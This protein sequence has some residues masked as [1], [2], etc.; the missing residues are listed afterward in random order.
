M[1]EKKLNWKPDLSYPAGKGATEQRF[2]ASANGD[3]LEIDTHPWGD[4]DLKIDGLNA[5]HVEGLASDGDA[6]RAAEN[7][8]E[9]IEGRHSDEAPQ[10]PKG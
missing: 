2:T 6:F 5:A 4:A 1:S 3:E 9:E 10:T 8:A 7:I